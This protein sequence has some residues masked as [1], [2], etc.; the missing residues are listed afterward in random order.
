MQNT[1][2]RFNRLYADLLGLDLNVLVFEYL[3]AFAVFEFC[4][5]YSNSKVLKMLH[6]M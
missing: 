6:E 5:G 1:C 4:H 2:R 3:N